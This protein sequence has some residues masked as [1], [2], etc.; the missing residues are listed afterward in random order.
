MCGKGL[1]G[2]RRDYYF[3]ATVLQCSMSLASALESRNPSV[4][5]QCLLH[6]L[7]GSDATIRS[8]RSSFLVQFLHRRCRII[9]LGGVTIFG[10]YDLVSWFMLISTGGHVRSG[11][12]ASA[13]ALVIFN[14]SLI[15]S[16]TI[17]TCLTVSFSLG[18]GL[19]GALAAFLKL[20]GIEGSASEGT[21]TTRLLEEA[22]AEDEPPEGGRRVCFSV[23]ESRKLCE[24]GVSCDEA[25][26][27]LD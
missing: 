9:A 8:E 14:I 2:A 1:L 26:R 3:V 18:S 19:A 7:P 6:H 20:E 13:S 22:G 10:D 24:A 15:M 5:C 12:F 27:L 4:D 23:G 16:S 21:G 11:Y 25:E 17:H